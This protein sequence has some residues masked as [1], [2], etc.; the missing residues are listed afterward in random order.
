MLFTPAVKGNGKVQLTN[1]H[2]LCTV[3]APRPAKTF[4]QA[5]ASL[6]SQCHI[7]VT[8]QRRTEELG[9][10]ILFLSCSFIAAF[11]FLIVNVGK[12]NIMFSFDFLLLIC[13]VFNRIILPFWLN[14][15][16]YCANL[17]NY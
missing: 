13:S 4:G 16:F 7:R 12:Q 15:L 17:L 1:F 10:S 3:K 6:T 11:L 9:Q 5:S 8:F 14:F 2:R